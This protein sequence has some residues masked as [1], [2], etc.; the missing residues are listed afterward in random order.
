MHGTTN[1]KFIKYG[2]GIHHLCVYII[3]KYR[4]KVDVTWKQDIKKTQITLEITTRHQ[5]VHRLNG[6][7]KWKPLLDSEV[8][9]AFIYMYA[10]TKVRMC[11]CLLC[12]GNGSLN[13]KIRRRHV[14]ET[15]HF[16]NTVARKRVAEFNLPS[17]FSAL[18]NPRATAICFICGTNVLLTSGRPSNVDVIRIEWK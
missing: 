17:N 12:H 2:N 9:M 14:S 13:N 10:R 11:E 1:I 4:G 7:C 5:N 15:A 3:I 18:P 8:L 16:M 6:T